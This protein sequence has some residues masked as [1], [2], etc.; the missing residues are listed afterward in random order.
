VDNESLL[1]ALKHVKY[2][3]YTRDIVSFGLVREARF[4]KGHATIALSLATTDPDIAAQLRT[5]IEKTLHHSG[6]PKVTVDIAINA[7]VA[8][9]TPTPINGVRHIIAIASGKGGVGKSTLATNLACAL[10]AQPGRAGRIGLLDSDIYGPSIPLMM[11]LAERPEVEGEHL[12]PPERFGVKTMSLGLLIDADAPVIWRGPMVQK[13]LRQFTTHVAWGELDILLA[14]LPP[15]TGDAHLAL[16]QATP[17]DGAVIITTPQRAA[18]TVAQRG[19]MLFAQTNIPLLGVIENMS[20]PPFGTGGG[21]ATAR[22]L[23]TEFLGHIPLDAT[24]RQS[25]D[26]GIPLVHSAPESP[27]SRKIIQIALRILEKTALTP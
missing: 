15:G 6:I 13:A 4:D 17:V 3:G 25:G 23:K 7:P 26:Q 19:A 10:A 8:A 12:L 16:I 11:G 5:D 14:D 18:T 27:L 9:P 1:N 21:E 22:A 2:P 20:G 24:L